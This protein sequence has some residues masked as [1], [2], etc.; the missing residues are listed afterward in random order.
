VEDELRRLLE[1]GDGQACAAWLGA[2]TPEERRALAPVVDAVP[3]ERGP[4]GQRSAAH[5]VAMAACFDGEELARRRWPLPFHAEG[6]TEVLVAV[7]PAWAEEWIQQELASRIFSFAVALDLA[8]AGV[9]PWPDHEA[10]IQGLINHAVR[11]YHGG[12]P[13]ELLE[14]HP[15][16]AAQLPRLFEVEGEGDGCLAAADKY[17]PE[18]FGWKAALLAMVEAGRLDRGETLDLC[19]GALGRGFS[20]F[21]AGWFSRFHDA[22]APTAAEVE[23]RQSSY[24]GLLA[25]EIGPSV[26]LALKALEKAR[27]AGVL[28]AAATVP[29]LEPATRTR[30][31]GT[32]RR[33][34]KLA[35]RIA[36]PEERAAL[37]QVAARALGHPEREVQEDALG[38]LE[39]HAEPGDPEVARVAGEAAST[40]VPTLRERLDP[41]VGGALPTPELAVTGEAAAPDPDLDAVPPMTSMDELEE[42]LLEWLGAPEDPLLLERLL[43]GA[44]RLAG[45]GPGPRA[46]KLAKLAAKVVDKEY[47]ALGREYP[48]L[49]RAA[50]GCLAHQLA[51]GEALPLP[52]E[53]RRRRVFSAEY[54]DLPEL[55]A[56]LARRVAAV[57]AT[58]QDGACL[59][60]LA[61]PTHLP[62][63]VAPG[64]LVERL[65][66]WEDAGRTPPALE[67]GQALLR[68]APGGRVGAA[69]EARTLRSEAGRALRYALGEN[70]DVGE[71][72]VIWVAAG[73]ARSPGRPPPEVASR[74]PGL[75]AGVDAPPEY[76]VRIEV[77]DRG[78]WTHR[79]LHVRTSPLPPADLDPEVLPALVHTGGGRLNRWQNR[80]VAGFT[81]ADVQR[82]ALVTP[83]DQEWFF[84]EGARTLDPEWFSAQWEVVEYLGPLR[85]PELRPGPMGCLLLTLALGAKEKG[86]RSAGAEVL[87]QASSEGRLDLEVVADWARR[88]LEPRYL[89]VSRFSKGLEQASR[90]GGADAVRELLDGVAPA[91]AG[92]G[93]RGIGALLQLWLELQVAADAGWD[94]DPTGLES[95]AQR[96]GKAA[97]AARALLERRAV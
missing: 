70:L 14:A 89:L 85:W 17:C 11:G 5:V 50:L 44:S 76:S 46:S 51:T 47:L 2:R 30:S 45:A 80:R 58:V 52:A 21:R 12:G 84:A 33:A 73:Q 34:L 88:L 81:S 86:Q 91:V 96:S 64:A 66:Q 10:W 22:L 60:L 79:K 49:P 23:E 72:P 15:R 55:G 57:L 41:W 83:A 37:V 36:G 71:D 26:T 38:L 42:G 75:G 94:G 59:P 7:R 4:Y 31:K 40:V 39:K 53:A 13:R 29:A 9:F 25:S 93:L 63:W 67:V 35:A 43:D 16:L 28:E 77:D 19:L 82:A 27:K 32:A 6:L 3:E 20:S 78:E 69:R 97:R 87:V 92:A 61:L 56:L 95:E 1:D 68:L 62:C 24:R 18:E 65:R 90:G 54:A 48:D 74:H 8:E